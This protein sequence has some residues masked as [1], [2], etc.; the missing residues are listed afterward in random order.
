MVDLCAVA[1][2]HSDWLLTIS[3]PNSKPTPDRHS[4]PEDRLTSVNKSYAVTRFPYSPTR[5]PYT[6]TR[7][8]YSP[9]RMPYTLT[10][11]LYDLRPTRYALN[12]KP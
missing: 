10:R 7:L 8:P 6:L 3:T 2:R 5:M 9:T 12:P 1:P 4:H 11:M